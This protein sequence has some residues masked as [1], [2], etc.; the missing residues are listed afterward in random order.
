MGWWTERALPR[1]ID[2]VL[3][4]DAMTP[5]RAAVCR[6]LTGRVLEIGFGSGLNV[7][8]YPT[9]VET[10]LAVEPSQVA[11]QLSE[12]R[13]TTRPLPIVRAGLDGQ[14]LDLDDA[15]VDAALSTFTLCSIPDLPAALAELRRVLRPGGALHFLEHGRAPDPGVRAWQRRLNPLQRRCAA[16]CR[17][18]RPIDRALVD[19]GFT[20]TGLET[21]YGPTRPRAMAYLYT[22]RATRD[23]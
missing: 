16:G 6:G 1:L 2:R 4:G 23:D 15:S 17:L 13:R 12:P 10:V 5:R 11:W 18:D 20:V 21:G 8:H 9:T 3:D 14:R 19:A 22:G 7:P